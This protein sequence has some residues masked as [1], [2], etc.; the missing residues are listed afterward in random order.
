MES[1]GPAAGVNM[2]KILGEL[3]SGAKS[4]C[5]RLLRVLLEAAPLSLALMLLAR[6]GLGKDLAALLRPLSLFFGLSA[7]GALVF[8]LSPFVGSTAALVLMGGAGLRLREATILA[9]MVLFS[10]DLVREA[11]LM[12]KGGSTGGKIPLIRL[13]VALAAGAAL[14]LIIP[15]R[16]GRGAFGLLP[17]LSSLELWPALGG[18]ALG[19]AKL[20]LAVFLVTLAVKAAQRVLESLRA[21]ELLSALLGPFMKFF[22]F[23]PEWSRFWVSAN[24]SG[25]EFCAVQLKGE[26]EAGKLKP[27]EGD[28]FN[29][30]A[31]FCH[32]LLEDSALY[33]VAGLSLFWVVIP[34][35][36]AAFACVW[37]E[38][39]R[40]QRFRRSFRAGVA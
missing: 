32:S 28:L 16:A 18:W 39:A 12:R 1:S 13:L 33:A 6:S 20:L 38:R 27:Q 2:Q 40:R 9:V 35:L 36:A 5:S 23:P 7:S 34:R 14:N 3:A 25:Y 24:V 4:A 17:G 37:I 21:L 22:G 26:I 19:M 15:A 10:H 30:H 31:A 29:C 11:S 8:A